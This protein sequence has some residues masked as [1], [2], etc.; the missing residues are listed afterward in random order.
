MASYQV[1]TMLS[2]TT[3]GVL[4]LSSRFVLQGIKKKVWGEDDQEVGPLMVSRVESMQ[5]MGNN[6]IDYGYANGM[7]WRYLS[8]HRD[9]YIFE[10]IIGRDVHIQVIHDN[11]LSDT[12]YKMDI[13]SWQ[14]NMNE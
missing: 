13:T 2:A 9:S 1:K 8:E 10:K 11:I 3:T 12:V 4:T 6:Y 7:L 5:L 14:I